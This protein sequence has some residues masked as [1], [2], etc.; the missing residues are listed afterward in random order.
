MK[1]K[2]RARLL[3]QEKT[4]YGNEAEKY[5]DDVYRFCRFLTGEQETSDDLAQETFLRF[6]RYGN[7]LTMKNV[8]GYLLTVARNVC[9]DWRR[10]KSGREF[11]LDE[12][13][14]LTGEYRTCK[15]DMSLEQTETRLALQ[16]ALLLLPDFQRE[17]L[18]LHYVFS[19]RYREIAEMT[20]V[21]GATVKSRV[22]QG[23]RKLR[24]LLGEEKDHDREGA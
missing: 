24:E 5:Y 6:L 3:G 4:E 10:E 12:N 8:K 18:L 13:W 21:S 9:R 7:A 22:R 2:I 15:Q 17:A 23:C 19:Y 11:P 14:E 16:E 1:E 20:G